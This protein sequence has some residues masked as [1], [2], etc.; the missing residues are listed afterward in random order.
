MFFL[1]FF[2]IK[3]Y[4]FDYFYLNRMGKK[5]ET[6]SDND[7]VQGNDVFDIF[8]EENDEAT[9]FSKKKQILSE[10]GRT[11]EKFRLKMKAIDILINIVSSNKQV[12][13]QNDIFDYETFKKLID[14][15]K[16]NKSYYDPFSKK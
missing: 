7:S 11:F 13:K 9:L 6:G 3:V 12:L 10:S 15:S 16:S 1:T 2:V 5:I 4:Y 14:I 8:M